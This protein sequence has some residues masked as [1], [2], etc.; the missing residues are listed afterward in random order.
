MQCKDI[1]SH[2]V[3]WIAPDQSAARAA[4]LMGFYN[5][6]FLPVCSAEGTP[7]GVIT[8]R[9]IALRVIEKYRPAA[10]ARVEEVMTA[11]VHSVGRDCP[12]T[13]AGELMMEAG[14]SR[15]LVVDEVGHLEGAISLGDLMVRG[16]G[17][18][19]LK[20]AR[21]IY[22]REMNRRP[23]G[24]PHPASNPNP[25]FFQGARNLVSSDSDY[26]TVENPARLEAEGVVRGGDNG[27][28]EF[29][30]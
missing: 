14:V 17:H 22:V 4:E 29:P 8:D 30:T 5:V 18:T 3:Q 23:N 24:R 1:M 28:R 25:K 10:Q 15:L 20:T 21:G 2:E 19:A 27:F 12:V 9:D 6:G 16:P 11:Q 7:L 26:P 13:T